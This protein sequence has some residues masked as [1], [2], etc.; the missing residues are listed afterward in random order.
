MCV[1]RVRSLLY[2]NI[3]ICVSEWCNFCDMMRN[4]NAHFIY[5]NILYTVVVFTSVW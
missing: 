1:L 3:L 5:M 4:D 2:V